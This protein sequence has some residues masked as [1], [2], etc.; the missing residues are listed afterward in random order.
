MSEISTLEPRIVWEQFDAITHIPRP[1][2]HEEQIISY[3]IE[4]A[5]LHQL[6][7]CRDKIGNVVI[8]KGATDG[9][10][11][12]STVVLQS[13]MDMVCEKNSDVEFDF[14]RDPIRVKLVGDWVRADGTPLGADCGIGMAAALALLLDPTVEHPPL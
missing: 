13:H 5:K 12:H 2:K 1:S 14:M 8:R 11:D 6:D 10:H 3:L 7:Y 4:F 9:Y